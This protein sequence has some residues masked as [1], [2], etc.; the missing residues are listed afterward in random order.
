VTDSTFLFITGSGRCGSTA[1]HESLIRHPDIGF[2]SNVDTYLAPLNL[3][4]AWNNELYR[5]GPKWIKQRERIK[6]RR[7]RQTRLHLGPSEGWRLLTRHVS[8]MWTEPFRDLTADDVTPWLE[9]RFRTFFEERAQ[10]QGKPVFVH[11]YTG[12][13]RTGFVSRILP[14]ARFLHVVRDGR[15]VAHSLMRRPWWRGH[16]GPTGWGFGPLPRTYEQEWE[17]HGRSFVALAGIEWKI[18]MDAFEAARAQIPTDRWMDVRYEDFIADPRRY[19]REILR[20]VGLEWNAEF[21][22]RLED[23]RYTDSRTMGFVS[24]LEPR[25]LRMLNE[26]LDDHLPLYGYPVEIAPSESRVT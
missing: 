17:R 8:P 21:D 5:L 13:P 1:V 26:I 23:F 7:V 15:A 4:G 2:I 24:E 20:F 3:K 12:W 25:H 14:E 22:R 16:L 19:L 9:R 6:G 18:F 11:K 10:A